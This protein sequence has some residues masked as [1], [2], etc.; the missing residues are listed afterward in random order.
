MDT[1]HATELRRWTEKKSGV[2]LGIGLGMAERSD[3]A[4]HGF[5][6]VAHMGYVNAHMTLGMLTV[7]DAGLKSLNIPHGEG[8]IEAASSVI[9]EA[10]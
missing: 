4:Y 2:T 8:V 5:L 6:H 9:S 7:I 1:P 10:K 3:P